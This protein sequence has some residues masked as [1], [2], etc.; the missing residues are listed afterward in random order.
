MRETKD[1]TG[2]EIEQAIIEANINAFDD[3]ERKP[4]TG[5]IQKAYKDILPIWS[6]FKKKT[7]EGQYP[8]VIR[9]AIAASPKE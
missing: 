1:H 6:S 2:A 3:N 7:E 9:M 8:L 5:D 4:N